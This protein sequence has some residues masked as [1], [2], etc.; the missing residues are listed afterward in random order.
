M[1]TLDLSLLATIIYAANYNN[2]ELVLLCIFVIY[3]VGIFLILL[4]SGTL[5]VCIQQKDHLRYRNI[6]LLCS[7]K[8]SGV[9]VGL[10]WR[11]R[12]E[13]VPWHTIQNSDINGMYTLDSA[14]IIQ[15]CCWFLSR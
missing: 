14:N 11:S 5:E 6:P 4:L 8:H 7:S 15:S 13:A 9:Q 10:V 1:H 2:A 3:H 12:T